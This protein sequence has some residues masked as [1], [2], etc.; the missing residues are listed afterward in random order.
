MLIQR[1]ALAIYQVIYKC[2]CV[3]GFAWCMGIVRKSSS[4]TVDDGNGCLAHRYIIR[5]HTRNLISLFDPWGYIR[6]LFP[7]AM[8]ATVLF[9][10]SS[11]FIPA[12]NVTP[13][14]PSPTQMPP[15]TT[16][17][18]L[19]RHM[20][21]LLHSHDS[22][23]S[24]YLSMSFSLIVGQCQ[25]QTIRLLYHIFFPPLSSCGTATIIS[26]GCTEHCNLK[27][28][29]FFMEVRYYRLLQNSQF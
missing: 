16:N 17:P 29:S 6:R 3:Y 15:T 4:Q 28:G 12:Q 8:C 11:F 20:H 26:L 25:R 19:V 10:L 22:L 14:H 13:F 1:D 18:T 21:Q 27:H 9:H 2:P 7:R 24:R 23:L 5:P